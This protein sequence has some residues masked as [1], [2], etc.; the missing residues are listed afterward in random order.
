[1]FLIG[2]PQPFEDCRPAS[3]NR[4]DSSLTSLNITLLT[5]FTPKTAPSQSRVACCLLHMNIALMAFSFNSTIDPSKFSETFSCTAF[6][7]PCRTKDKFILNFQRVK[8][9]LSWNFGTSYFAD[10]DD[11]MFDTIM[12]YNAPKSLLRKA[13]H[14]IR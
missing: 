7:N 14:S 4:V 11:T 5:S 8:L 3:S 9:V 12:S 1:M 13:L 2:F 10:L 6:Y